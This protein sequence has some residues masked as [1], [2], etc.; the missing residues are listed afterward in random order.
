MTASDEPPR[1]L[2]A[3]VIPTRR[4]E[5]RL[6]IALDALAAQ[7]LG[8]QYFEVVVV[9]DTEESEPLAAPP[10]ELRVRFLTIAPTDPA[11]KR[12]AGWRASVAPLVAFTDDDCRPSPGWLEALLAAAG[13]EEVFLQGR[14]EVDPDERHLMVGLARSQRIVGPSGWF[15]TC[16]MAYPRALMERLDGFDER[17]THGGEDTDL[18]CRAVASGARREYVDGALVWHAVLPNPLPLALGDAGRHTSLPLLVARHPEVRRQ[19]VLGTFQT[20]SHLGILLAALGAAALPRRPALSLLASL[21]YVAMNVDPHNLRP[22]SVAGY[23]VHMPS[24]AILDLAQT[25]SIIRSAI[26]HRVPMA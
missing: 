3:V 13:G 17:F 14:T 11:A 19:L 12:E 4:R 26:H 7:T 15:E 24:R 18:G 10:S 20:R 9:R 22:R 21:P 16:N 8:R 2:V 5:T 1:P 23:L 6:A 25:A